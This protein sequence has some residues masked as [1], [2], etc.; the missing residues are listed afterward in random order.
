M[1]LVAGFGDEVIVALVTFV[2]VVIVTLI[3]KSTRVRQDR[4]FG[5]APVSREFSGPSKI[6]FFNWCSIFLNLASRLSKSILVL[7]GPRA[8]EPY[9]PNTT[10]Q[11]E[12]SSSPEFTSVEEEEYDDSEC[13]TIKVRL[14]E[15]V[16]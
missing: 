9:N 3:W 6:N 14:K 1:S 4:I 5:V 2:V 8:S 10:S 15:L 11:T 16:Y 13:A 7:L 12:Q